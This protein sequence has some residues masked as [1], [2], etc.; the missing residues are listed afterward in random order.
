MK[1]Y[2]LRIFFLFLAIPPILNFILGQNTPNNIGV[3]GNPETWLGFYG[4]YL[5]GVITAL[6]GFYTIYRSERVSALQM[7]IERKR[8]EIGHLEDRLAECVSLFDFSKVGIVSLYLPNSSKFNDVLAELNDYHN[9]VTTTANAW[10]TIYGDSDCPYIKEFQNSY[11][12]C[13]DALT[14]QINQVSSMI[15]ELQ[16]VYL[17]IK[18][19]EGST[20]EAR[21]RTNT[22]RVMELAAQLDKDQKERDSIIRAISD[23]VSQAP[24]NKDK[25]LFPLQEQARIWISEEKKHLQKLHEA[26]RQ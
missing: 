12:D 23:I 10:S 2:K 25:Y 20:A 5:G 1:N 7:E 17:N 11:V 16:C 26:L 9:K 14:K 3:I 19:L 13:W 21:T 4:S 6:I 24:M 22:N 8:E 18:N 15:V